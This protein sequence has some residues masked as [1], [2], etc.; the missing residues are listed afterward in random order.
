MVES[1]FNKNA[2]IDSRSATL[3]KRS[4][5]Q[6]CFPVNTQGFSMFHEKGLT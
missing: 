2:V 4:F 3:L 1:N 6:G 5:H